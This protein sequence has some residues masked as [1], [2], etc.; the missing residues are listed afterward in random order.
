MIN[1][2]K[3]KQLL[4][5]LKKLDEVAKNLPETSYKLTVMSLAMDIH[6]LLLGADNMPHIGPK[7]LRYAEQTLLLAIKK[8]QDILTPNK[9]VLIGGLAVNHWVQV[10]EEDTHMDY[11]F[12]CEN[13][14]E[15]KQR[16]PDGKNLPLTYSFQMDDVNFALILE[17]V[18]P[19]TEEA[20][21]T[22]V[23]SPILGFPIALARPEYLILYKYKSGTKY[24]FEMI[25]YIL[26][27]KGVP[28]LT[29]KLILQY[30]PED[31]EDFE[32][33]VREAEFG[34]L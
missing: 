3:Q 22:A 6:S 14:L 30:L 2:Y 11:A 8:M 28:E 12:L 29:R 16:F 19:W 24:D 31:Y 23:T 26:T 21:R 25:K 27:L 4:R 9:M 32:A 33:L 15:V 34:L 17:N 5:L 13:M 10:R 20:I 7:N 18:Y 1:K